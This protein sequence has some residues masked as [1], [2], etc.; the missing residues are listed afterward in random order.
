MAFWWCPFPLL[1]SI[2]EQLRADTL[3]RWTLDP[4]LSPKDTVLIAPAPADVMVAWTMGDMSHPLDMPTL[5]YGYRQLLDLHQHQQRPV[6]SSFKKTH[7][8]HPMIDHLIAQVDQQ[9]PDILSA[10]HQLMSVHP[11]P[12]A[13]DQDPIQLWSSYQTI[14]ARTISTQKELLAQ[15]HHHQR[16]SRR[17][18]NQLLKK[19]TLI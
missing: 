10:A 18:T 13:V 7:S 9:H 6:R 5:K 11:K 19:M 17:L 8:H 1:N 4:E 3:H 2:Q 16:I 14:Q 15:H 12:D